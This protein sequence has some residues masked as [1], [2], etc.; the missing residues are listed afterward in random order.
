MTTP[1]PPSDVSELRAARRAAEASPTP[2]RLARL[3]RA[4]DAVLDDVEPADD[5]GCDGGSQS[6]V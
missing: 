3:Y 1:V 4:V 2:G 5:D 6:T